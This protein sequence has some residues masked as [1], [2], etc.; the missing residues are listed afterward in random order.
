DYN[1]HMSTVI[2]SVYCSTSGDCA[3]GGIYH[4][5]FGNQQVVD[6]A[7]SPSG[8]WF[9][10][11]IPASE[12]VNGAGDAVVTD[13]ACAAPGDCA[14]AGNSFPAAGD[15]QA[16][17]DDEDGAAWDGA[18]ELLGIVNLSGSAAGPVSCGGRG[19]CVT[20]GWY[21]DTARHRQAFYANEIQHRWVP[22]TR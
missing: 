9:A 16:L 4:D 20:G 7:K 10:E 8:S 14:G 21:I 1:S 19:D 13:I 18:V 22:P 3:L 2:E 11:T 5:S 6:A 12:E 15:Q 17:V